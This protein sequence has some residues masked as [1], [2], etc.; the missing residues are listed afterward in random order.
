MIID[1]AAIKSRLR[2]DYQLSA[3]APV[4]V[5]GVW[6]K[7]ATLDD[8]PGNMD[9]E[10]IATTDAVDCDNEVVLPG[11]ADFASYL[12]KN[13]AIFVDHEYGAMTT[14]G[15]LRSLTPYPDAKRQRGW[16]A[17]V[18]LLRNTDN[19]FVK[20][21]RALAE[22][23]MLGMSIGFLA[24]DYGPPTEDEKAMYPRARSIVRRWQC[25]EI[26]YTTMPCNVECQT[27]AVYVDESKA[28]KVAEVVAK[29]D[30]PPVVRRALHL[31]PAPTPRP[32]LVVQY[33]RDA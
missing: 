9:I 16:K 30:A 7:E 11:G 28:A 18:A 8:S 27:L 15:K 1:A 6:C 22:A 14:V 20:Q 24:L 3:D 25:L 23:G 31:P 17:R 5:S 2:A 12:A 26:S 29:S 13:K 4:G 32:K 33:R 19:P 10:A 21:V